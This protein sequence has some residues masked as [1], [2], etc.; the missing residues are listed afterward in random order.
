MGRTIKG[1]ENI[2]VSMG[3]GGLAKFPANLHDNGGV[4]YSALFPA[5]FSLRKETPRRI[6]VTSSLNE[7][8]TD[9]QRDYNSPYLLVNSGSEFLKALISEHGHF[10]IMFL[11]RD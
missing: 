8:S 3:R 11:K 5:N 10:F 2:N 1:I 6:T 7:I 9:Q 4:T